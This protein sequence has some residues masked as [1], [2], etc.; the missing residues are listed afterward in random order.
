MEEDKWKVIPS[1]TM[2]PRIEWGLYL[3]SD[4][5]VCPEYDHSAWKVDRNQSG[6][7]VL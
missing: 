6:G 1:K 3:W 7:N 2:N 5:R 4:V